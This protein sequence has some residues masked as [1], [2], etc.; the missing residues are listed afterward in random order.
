M[1]PAA[2][3]KTDD[4]NVTL[5][6]GGTPATAL[7]Q[8]S[9]ITAGWTGTLAASRGGFGTSVAA[10]S[11]VPLF[12][13]GV[14]TFTATTGTGN[15]VRADSP[16]L[17][18]NPTAPTPAVADNDTSIAT[19]AFVTAAVAAGGGGGASVLVAD[20]AP[21]GAPDNSLW[22][23]SDTG[24]LYIRYNDLTSTQWASVGG[25]PGPEGPAGTSDWAD[26]TSKPATFPPSTH[27]HLWADLTDKPATFP[28]S[29][30]AHAIADVTNLQTTLNAKAPLATIS[31]G[32]PSG[33]VD[34]DV[35]YLV[36]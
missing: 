22:W 7:L 27:T 31:T 1:T 4:A 26:I 17:T 15:F 10:S 5:A 25:P 24:V 32:A 2:L 12:A 30:H 34:G 33:G 3:S 29:T 21:V 20:T 28:P 23:E 36:V 35:W 18:G 19:T 6:L 9:S 8:A 14:P 16:A 13:T 11:G